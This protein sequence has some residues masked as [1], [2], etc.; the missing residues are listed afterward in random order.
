ME[1]RLGGRDSS[2]PIER[3]TIP[4]PTGLVAVVNSSFYRDRCIGF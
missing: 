4:E 3:F 1:V 2:G